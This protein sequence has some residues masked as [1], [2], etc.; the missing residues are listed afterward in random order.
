MKAVKCKNVSGA[1]TLAMQSLLNSKV[2][3]AWLTMHYANRFSSEMPIKLTKTLYVVVLFHTRTIIET[4]IKE[5]CSL[6]SFTIYQAKVKS[7]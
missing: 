2:F 6:Q 7:V 3:Q 4:E 1:V 5:K